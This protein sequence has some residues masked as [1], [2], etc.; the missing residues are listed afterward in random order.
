MEVIN[1]ERIED[2]HDNYVYDIETN[3]GTYYVNN[4][5]LKNTDSCYVTFHINK[6]DFTDD[7]GV[8]DE[9]AYMKENFRISKECAE[10][11]TNNFKKPIQ[12]EFEKIMYPFFL[13]EKKRYAYKNWVQYEHPEDELEY[14]G[15]AIKRRDS[16]P[17]VKTVCGRLFEIL[18]SG[19]DEKNLIEAKN[20]AY[21]SLND[22]YNGKVPIKELVMSNSLKDIY[23]YKGRD[24]N[25]TKK[26]KI[27]NGVDE[28]G[29]ALYIDDYDPDIYNIPKPHV[30]I[31]IKLREIDPITAPKPPDRVEILYI[32]NKHAKLAHE[33]AIHPSMYDNKKYKIDYIYYVEHQ[34]K[35]PMEAIL[36]EIIKD[37][38]KMY[39]EQ[40]RNATLIQKGQT[41]IK[42]FFMK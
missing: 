30:Q 18:M 37:F 4:I 31:A 40:L 36:K 29:N 25:W 11:I 32:V 27:Q 3:D 39:A 10:K 35:N 5:L 34:L 41:T 13:Y 2:I 7:N 14:K 33:K 1:I 6:E 38:D 16:C 19:N 22:L 15:L 26:I 12:L 42:S 20:Y 8:F 9:K 17:Y 24:I 28:N 23:K 21:N